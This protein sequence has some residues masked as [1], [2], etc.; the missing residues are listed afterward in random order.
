MLVFMNAF[1]GSVG[2][3]VIDKTE[4][5][6]LFDIPVQTLDV[7]P[8]DMV[9]GPSVWPAI[10]EQIGFKLESAKAP[11]EILMIDHAEKPSEN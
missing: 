6:G 11:V 2:R 5:K 8:F 4:I 10:V 9:F 3:P 1:Q 7:G